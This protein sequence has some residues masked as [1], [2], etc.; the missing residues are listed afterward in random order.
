MALATRG[1]V[2]GAE[3]LSAAPQHVL[4]QRKSA[5]A[6][7]EMQLS[8]E[9]TD[10]MGGAH[11][12]MFS[13]ERNQTWRDNSDHSHMLTVGFL[14]SVNI[15]PDPDL[16]CDMVLSMR[17][18][19]KEPLQEVRETNRK[20]CLLVTVLECRK[21][22]KADIFG[23]NDVFAT[24][25]VD[26]VSQQTATVDDGGTAPKWNGGAGESFLFQDLEGLPS[27]MAVGIWDEDV[28]SASDL[29]GDMNVDLTDAGIAEEED[30]SEA[31]WYDLNDDKGKQVGEVHM[32]MRWGHPPPALDAP[33]LWQVRVKVLECASLKKMDLLGKNDVYVKVHVGGSAGPQR[34][35]TIDGGGAEPKWGSGAGEVMTFELSEPPPSVGIEVFDEDRDAD[36]LIGGNVFELGTK[37]GDRKEWSAE[38]WLELTDARNKVTGKARVAIFWERKPPARFK[39]ACGVVECKG[40]IK[41]D[42]FGKND[43]YVSLSAGNGQ[44]RRTTTIDGGG[45]APVW[46]NGDGETVEWDVPTAP[47]SLLVEV[48]DEDVGSKDDLLGRLT[49][50]LGRVLADVG[51]AQ[52]GAW[53]TL[54]DAKGQSAGM[55]KLSLNWHPLPSDD[56][57]QQAFTVQPSVLPSSTSKDINQRIKWGS[58]QV[59]KVDDSTYQKL[60]GSFY[61]VSRPDRKL[62]EFVAGLRSAEGCRESYQDMWITVRPPAPTISLN[63]KWQVIPSGADINQPVGIATLALTELLSLHAAPQTAGKSGLYLKSIIKSAGTRQ[64]P[65]WGEVP[66]PEIAKDLSI[67]PIGKTVVV[68]R[69][70]RISELRIEIMQKASDGG[71]DK[72]TCLLTFVVDL[73]AALFV[74]NES[75]DVTATIERDESDM[76][77]AEAYRHFEDVDEDGSGFLERDEIKRLAHAVGQELGEHELD[78]AMKEMDAD[79][80][81]EV[82]FEEYYAWWQAMKAAQTKAEE[83]GGGGGA[84]GMLTRLFARKKKETRSK[85]RSLVSKAMRT[86]KDSATA[87][88]A[89]DAVDADNSGWLDAAEIR[90]LA[91][92]LGKKMEDDE[93]ELAMT[94]MRGNATEIDAARAAVAAAPAESAAAAAATAELE[95]MMSAGI[96]FD[97]FNEWWQKRGQGQSAGLRGIR[98]ALGN[99]LLDGI[100]HARKN[101]KQEQ[102]IA[103]HT[104]VRQAFDV[105]DVST[106][107]YS[108]SNDSC[109]FILS[110]S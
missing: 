91:V 27:A 55:V 71:T 52:A 80:S 6:E 96:T 107:N 35:V 57:P 18:R 89:F 24:L 64:A 20:R 32:L 63:C 70:G 46:A 93:L 85:G 88:Q 110:L 34:T 44:T 47:E 60:E 39:L 30:W 106:R 102:A 29:I 79:G 100:M 82:D 109:E 69:L 92:T 77:R 21:L 59:F 49:L 72:D 81:G 41:A 10:A 90:Q 8:G 45:E 14:Q 99:N 23:K 51:H 25:S 36:D 84:G 98:G 87:R 19:T 86:E 61:L 108:A 66:L 54:V 94:E 1:K 3:S 97:Q 105:I 50:P 65:S 38:R 62:G 48:W 2:G 31:Q 40:L 76:M 15:T 103:Q 9:V 43:V 73:S 5:S 17:D 28:G 12:R 16:R 7:G 22:K 33:K 42:R 11:I 67:I 78:E 37:V 83:E 75:T 58:S 95:A 104:Q 13:P 74:E 68:R 101:K 56:P 26:G 53:Q 4:R